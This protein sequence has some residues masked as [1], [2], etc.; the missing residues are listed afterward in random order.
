LAG[1]RIPLAPKVAELLVALVESRGAVVTRQDL[2]DRLWPD[3]H[4]DRERGLN[5]AVNRL[6]EALG[7]SASSPRFIETVPKRGYRFLPVV[8]EAIPSQW[9]TNRWLIAAAALLLVVF[10]ASLRFRG[11]RP[12]P[13]EAPAEYWAAVRKLKF[14]KINELE[15]VKGLLQA[16]IQKSP[17]YA[18]AH[19]TLANVLLDLADST[20]LEELK[21]RN[22]ASESANYARLALLLDPNSMSYVASAQVHLRVDWRLRD[23]EREIAEALRLDPADAEAWRAKATLLL[24]TGDPNGAVQAARRASE[25]DPLSPWMRTACARARFYAGDLDGA[26]RD[27]DDTRRIAPDFGPAYRFLMEVHWEAGREEEARQAYLDAMRVSGGVE[28]ADLRR[29]E[30]ETRRMGMAAYWRAQ[31][32][33]SGPFHGWH[34]VPYKLASRHAMLGDPA[35][36]LTWLERAA[37]QR[38]ARLLFLRVNPQFKHLR[39]LPGYQALVGRLFL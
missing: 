20:G 23:A 32:A 13:V 14:G 25:L 39:A 35:S 10:A 33:D 17:R 11:S 12:S 18:P 36:A 4:T 5:N 28:P 19:A 24:A 2:Q 31:V 37:S 8:T 29:A 34:G 30:S 26:V 6:R 22:L 9:F 21:Y 7:D 16:A 3:T 27:L 38:D 15:E 1:A